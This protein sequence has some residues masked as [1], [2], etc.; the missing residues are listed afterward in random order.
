MLNATAYDRQFT[1]VHR[2]SPHL[3]A[4]RCSPTTRTSA[5]PAAAPLC[6]DMTLT[7][8]WHHGALTWSTGSANTSSP[9]APAPPG[10][11]QQRSQGFVRYRCVAVGQG[12]GCCRSCSPRRHVIALLHVRS[13]SQADVQR[14]PET[15]HRHHLA[16]LIRCPSR[17]SPLG[18]SPSTCLPILTSPLLK[19]PRHA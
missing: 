11:S 10:A 4:S 14:I 5:L 12:E 1:A 3:T 2:S 7:M 19:P 13:R 17:I 9:S 6:L 15:V 18:C 8:A 16:R